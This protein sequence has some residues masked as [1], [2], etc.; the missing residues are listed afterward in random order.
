MKNVILAITV[1][2]SI[3]LSLI[4]I[5]IIHNFNPY[6]SFFIGWCSA[7]GYNLVLSILNYIDKRRKN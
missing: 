5:G 7:M 4:I 3:L 2:G 1:S 6:L